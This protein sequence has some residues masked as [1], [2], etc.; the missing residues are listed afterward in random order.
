MARQLGFLQNLET[1]KGLPAQYVPG[2]PLPEEANVLPS[3]EALQ[4]CT[5][6]SED[7]R[8]SLPAHFDIPVESSADS[9]NGDCKRV[10]EVEV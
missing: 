6:E 1:R 5:G 7:T 2:D 10:I 3:V 9:A 4:C 8:P